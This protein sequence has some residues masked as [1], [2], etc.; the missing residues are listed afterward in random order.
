MEAL[1]DADPASERRM[2]RDIMREW[3]EAEVSLAQPS[4][5]RRE[6]IERARRVMTLRLEYQRVTGV[7]RDI[8]DSLEA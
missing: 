5:G 7:S 1:V 6:L 3:R 4:L 8:D 2:P